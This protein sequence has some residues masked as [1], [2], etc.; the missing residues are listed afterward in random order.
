MGTA[1]Q[2]LDPLRRKKGKV[3]VG[4]LGPEPHRTKTRLPEGTAAVALRGVVRSVHWG[5]AA[6]VDGS[7][8]NTGGRAAG[9]EAPQSHQDLGERCPGWGGRGHDREM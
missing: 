5:A 4:Q 6:H 9:A 7:R 1:R 2:R 8:K 3:W